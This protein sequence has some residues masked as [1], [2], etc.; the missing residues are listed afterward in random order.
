LINA[1]YIFN[2]H[3]RIVIFHEINVY[4]R[5]DIKSIACG[6]FVRPAAKSYLTQFC[7]GID[8]IFTSGI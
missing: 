5:W 1:A 4:N 3:K 6:N 7:E 8:Q 2:T